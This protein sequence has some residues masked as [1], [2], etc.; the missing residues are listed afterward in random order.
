MHRSNVPINPQLLRVLNSFVGLTDVSPDTQ[1][2]KTL[3]HDNCKQRL[4]QH[5]VCTPT[6]MNGCPSISPGFF[7]P[8]PKFTSAPPWGIE[9]N[10]HP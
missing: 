6:Q 1:T 4:F 8:E 10:A 7:T 9:M 5:L 2:Y 3:T